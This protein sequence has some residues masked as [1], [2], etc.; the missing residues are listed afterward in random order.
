MEKSSLLLLSL[1]LSFRIAFVFVSINAA[2]VFFSFFFSPVVV[3]VCVALDKYCLLKSIFPVTFVFF[4]VLS[5]C[6]SRCCVR[7]SDAG[8]GV[9]THQIKEGK[10][11]QKA[12]RL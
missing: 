10:R 8:G 6:V 3:C 9:V 5:L 2:S 12:K 4:S 1:L 7:L 11:K